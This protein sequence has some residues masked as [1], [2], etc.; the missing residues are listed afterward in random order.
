[1]VRVAGVQAGGGLRARSN[2][3][4]RHGNEDS[5]DPETLDRRQGRKG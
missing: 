3:T 4:K 1:M 5:L 2:S